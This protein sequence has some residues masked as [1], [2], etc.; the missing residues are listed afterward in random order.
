MAKWGEGDPRWIVEERPDATNVNNWHW[1]E[2]NA[3]SWSKKKLVDLL[4]NLEISD[5]KVGKISIVELS[6][7]EGEARVNNRKA[8]L[9]FLYE[10]VLQLKWVGVVNGS[11]EKV[12]GTLEIPNLSE[13]HTDMADV[14]ITIT[15]TSPSTPESQRLKNFLRK[16]PGAKK[17][18]DSLAEYVSALKSEFAQGLILP[19]KD[20][21][22]P[23][24]KPSPAP[25]SDPKVKNFEKLNIGGSSSS[26]PPSN[27]L[28]LDSFNMTETFKCTG[29]EIYS[30]LTQ[31]QMISVFTGSAAQMSDEA[32]VGE[33]FDI[34]NGNI[35]GE[36]MELV[37]Y[38]K[39]VQKWRL[40]SW[41]PSEHY[42]T[43]EISMQQRED[44][45]QLSVSLK[46]VPAKEVENTRNGWKRYYWESIKRV[47]G[48]GSVLF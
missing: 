18:R 28:V 15:T 8:K 44:S 29:M 36:F 20:E 23:K 12:E 13:E 22:V 47:F 5:E 10:W 43:V 6:K 25:K 45:T 35:Q 48:Y 40:E 4:T 21:K 37:P 3:D 39:I 42:S 24:A 16:G 2:K 31:K 32:K 41:V 7:M 38:T 46:N 14:D 1:T 33:K 9:I 27:K 19:N 11:D 17:I 26:S 34:L 30:A